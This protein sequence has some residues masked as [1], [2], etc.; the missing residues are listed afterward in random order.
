VTEQEDRRDT[1]LALVVALVGIAL[2]LL[3]MSCAAITAPLAAHP[4]QVVAGWLLAQLM[5]LSDILSLLFGV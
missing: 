3:S 1:L 5:T 2:L 4:G